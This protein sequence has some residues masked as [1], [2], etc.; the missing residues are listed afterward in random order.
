MSEILWLGEPGRLQPLFTSG[1]ELSEFFRF[2]Q[3]IHEVG[4]DK[5]AEYK[6]G[7]HF[8]KCVL[9]P[10]EY[11]KSDFFKKVDGFEKQR[12]TGAAEQE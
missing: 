1:F 6:K 11:R 10:P 9:K 8:S 7:V 4:E 3:H 2:Q 5:E 12:E